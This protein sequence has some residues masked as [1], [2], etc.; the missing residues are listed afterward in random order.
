M[1]P[2]QDDLAVDSGRSSMHRSSD[3]GTSGDPPP[4]NP[5]PAAPGPAGGLI[6]PRTLHPGPELLRPTPAGAP[7]PGGPSATDPSPPAEEPAQ[8][9]DEGPG[10]VDPRA[11]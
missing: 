2:M 5:G 6:D 3:P 4:E 7:L 9:D 8:P 10:L 1:A 11:G